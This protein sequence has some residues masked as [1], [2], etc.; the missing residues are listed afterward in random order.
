MQRSRRPSANNY[1]TGFQT[2]RIAQIINQIDMIV[3]YL[4]FRISEIH[5]SH[6]DDQAMAALHPK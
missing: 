2:Y 5:D 6:N 1:T 3:V 4:T